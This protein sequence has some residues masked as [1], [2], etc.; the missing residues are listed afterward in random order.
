M[1][2]GTITPGT[3]LLDTEAASDR[4][5]APVSALPGR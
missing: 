5:S 4:I 2:T 1:P 3:R